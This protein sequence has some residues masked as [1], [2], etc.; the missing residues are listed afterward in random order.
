M[1]R[2]KHVPSTFSQL[3]WIQYIPLESKFQKG[4]K[5]GLDFTFCYVRNYL[6][7]VLMIQVNVIIGDSVS[8]KKKWCFGDALHASL[9]EPGTMPLHRDFAYV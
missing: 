1:S 5:L 8:V 3:E 7:K 2:L 9:Q 6:Q 4:D